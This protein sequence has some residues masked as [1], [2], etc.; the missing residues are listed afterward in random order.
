MIY[1]LKLKVLNTVYE[2]VGDTVI[3]A[4]NAL[5][6]KGMVRTVGILTV[7]K[8]KE[9]REKI[10]APRILARLYTESRLMKEVA[11]KNISNLFLGF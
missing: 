3:E 9:S 8:G 7:T 11:I 1:A 2:S 6:L 5:K 10:L 4:L